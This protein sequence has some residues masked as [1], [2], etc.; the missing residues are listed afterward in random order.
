MMTIHQKDKYNNQSIHGIL[1]MI[2]CEQLSKGLGV[3]T[4]SVTEEVTTI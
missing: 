2:L 3:I 1:T 4:I